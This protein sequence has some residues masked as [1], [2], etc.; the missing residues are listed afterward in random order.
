LP[1]WA[2]PPEIS[3]FRFYKILYIAQETNTE[4]YHNSSTGVI[5]AKVI[6]YLHYF[7]LSKSQFG[8][9]VVVIAYLAKPGQYSKPT[10]N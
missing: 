8:T 5:S 10:V 2:I 9:I 6:L 3:H 7:S 4:R 1:I